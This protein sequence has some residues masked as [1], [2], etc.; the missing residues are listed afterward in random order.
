MRK[1]KPYILSVGILF[2]GLAVGCFFLFRTLDFNNNPEKSLALLVSVIGLIFGVFQVFLNLT[3]QGERSKTQLRHNDYK[4]LVKSLNSI[5]DLMNESLINELNLNGLVAT[6]LNKKNEYL[7][8][9]VH[10][11]DYLFTGLKNNDVIKNCLYT[12]EELGVRTDKY[13]Y[14]LGKV[15]G[16]KDS[17]IILHMNWHNDVVDILKRYNEF[18]YDV[19][20]VVRKNI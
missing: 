10:N 13:R 19:L 9:V 5:S 3:V 20:R 17:G 12:I 18:K 6:L 8:F 16:D 14:E 2:I 1:L 15:D 4:E 11:D 7:S